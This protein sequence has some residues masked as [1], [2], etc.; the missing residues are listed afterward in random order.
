VSDMIHHI[1]SDLLQCS[2]CCLLW[3]IRAVFWSGDMGCVYTLGHQPGSSIVNNVCH[4]V[5]SY[6]YGGWAYYTDEGSRDEL[7]TRNIATRTKCSGHHQHYGTDNN[8]TNNLYYDVN[9]GDRPSPGRKEIIMKD[10]DAA[11]RASTH[12]R[13]DSCHPQKAPNASND[14]CCC[15]PNQP[16]APDCDDGKCSSFVFER[17]AVLQPAG[18]NGSLLQT[19]FAQGLAN[20]TFKNNDWYKV[21]DQSGSTK[22][23][24]TGWSNNQGA[25]SFAE[26]QQK[27]RDAGSVYAD[28]QLNTS[29]WAL[30]PSSPA[31]KLGFVPI[32][33]SAVGPRPAVVGAATTHA[34]PSNVYNAI[35]S[36]LFAVQQSL[37][38]GSERIGQILKTDDATIDG[39]KRVPTV[40]GFNSSQLPWPWEWEE[41]AHTLT[42]GTSSFRNC[43]TLDRHSTRDCL[44]SIRELDLMLTRDVVYIQGY[45]FARELAEDDFSPALLE[46]RALRAHMAARGSSKPYAILGYRGDVVGPSANSTRSQ[47]ARDPAYQGFWLRDDAGEYHDCG[48]LDP[49]HGAPDCSPLWDFRNASARAFYIEDLLRENNRSTFDG[50][51]VD[52]GDAVAMS[53]NLT[54]QTRRDIFNATAQLWKELSIEANTAASDRDWR[55]VFVVTPSLKD[56]LGVDLDGDDGHPVCNASTPMDV[57]CAPY[58]EEAIYAVIGNKVWAPHRQFNFPSRDFGK[59]SAGCAALARTV[60]G[61]GHRGPQML[62]CNGCNQSTTEGQQMFKASF[63]AYLIGAERHSYFGAG[64]HFHNDSAWDFAWPDLQRPIGEPDGIATVS[65]DGLHFR[66]VFKHVT[67]ELDCVNQTG[68]IR[69][70]GSRSPHGRLPYKSDDSNV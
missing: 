6:N 22:L 27:G 51:F 50:V 45:D 70:H 13:P 15:F 29:T 30:A 3:L 69:W 5:Q 36:Q 1:I 63:A 25:S 66:R 4:D 60:I 43:S 21:G 24:N 56:H 7:F 59:N 17:N 55:P 57:A 52:S 58:G 68:M 61:Q 67:A 44:D 8:L 28:P 12:S 49:R 32:D 53:V 46:A 16:G 2:A 23:F 18:Y 65:S 64:M 38:M 47:Y 35:G 9:Q 40:D 19:T 31:R 20:F 39:I 37:Y 41:P 26:W 11:I 34:V 33:V 54:V 14:R 48:L 62:T 10:C 42:W